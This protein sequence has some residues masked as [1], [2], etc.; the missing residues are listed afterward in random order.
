MWIYCNP[1]PH[2]LPKRLQFIM[3]IMGTCLL[4]PKGRRVP[5]MQVIQ[6]LHTHSHT[7]SIFV[8]QFFFHLAIKDIFC[9]K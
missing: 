3:Y 9:L 8:F 6:V 1:N 2:H 7:V 5:T 4:S